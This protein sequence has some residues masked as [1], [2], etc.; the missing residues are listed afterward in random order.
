[1]AVIKGIII[2]LYS[3]VPAIRITKY[4]AKNP[5][6][7]GK[8]LKDRNIIIN[9]YFNVLLLIKNICLRLLIFI[10]LKDIIIAVNIIE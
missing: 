10:L 8:P 3:E 2:N 7:G 1:M 4:L 5:L 9:R 6:K